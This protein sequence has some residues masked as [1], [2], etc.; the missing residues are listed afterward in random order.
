MTHSNQE[1]DI[2]RSSGAH[3]I[4]F[5]HMDVL[6]ADSLRVVRRQITGLARSAQPIR[7]VLDLEDV[8]FLTSEA[9]GMVVALGNAIAPRGGRVHLANISEETCTV[10]EIFRLQQILDVFDSTLEAIE[11]FKEDPP[12][13]KPRSRAV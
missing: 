11:A 6:E 5:P 3:V 4:R 9:I 13:L 8:T 1:L 7:L 2:T 12:H 10:F